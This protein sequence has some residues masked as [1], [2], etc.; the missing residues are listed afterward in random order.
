ME[1]T[2]CDIRVGQDHVLGLPEQKKVRISGGSAADAAGAI[3]RVLE[4]LGELV[5]GRS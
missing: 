1:E 2:K 3:W 5:A 4:V